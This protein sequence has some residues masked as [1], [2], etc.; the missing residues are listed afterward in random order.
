MTLGLVVEG[1]ADRRSLPC[2]HENL[3]NSKTQNNLGSSG[4]YI[5][6]NIIASLLALQTPNAQINEVAVS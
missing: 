5:P 3:P 6:A 2:G 4:K 1:V